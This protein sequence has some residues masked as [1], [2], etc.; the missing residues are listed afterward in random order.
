MRLRGKRIVID[1]L[2][3]ED[4]LFFPNWGK[5]E[6]PLMITTIINLLQPISSL[7]SDA[8]FFFNIITVSRMAVSLIFR[9]KR[10][11]YLSRSSTLGLVMDPN[12]SNQGYASKPW[13]CF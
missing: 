11:N 8:K 12:F 4:A 5:H 6:I 1:E 3:E 2:K 13:N 9:M 10:I 7:V